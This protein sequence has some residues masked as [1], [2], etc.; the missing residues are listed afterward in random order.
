MYVLI[1]FFHI[2]RTSW[3]ICCLH[4]LPDLR[5]TSRKL[6]WFLLLTLLFRCNVFF[7]STEAIGDGESMHDSPRD[8]ALQNMSADD[9]PDS[10]SQVAQPQSSAF[11][12]R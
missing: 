3:F 1:C 10:A 4:S 8:E 9:L 12:Y 11:S 7:V 6:V 2:S 5:I